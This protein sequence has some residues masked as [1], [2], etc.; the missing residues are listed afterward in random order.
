MSQLLI[1]SDLAVGHM[2]TLGI[3]R[4]IAGQQVSH[5]ADDTIGT[6]GLT[7]WLKGNVVQLLI[8]LIGAGC[9]LAA[10]KVQMAK[11]M[12]MVGGTLVAL[13]V[14]GL[15]NPGMSDKVG[16]FLFGLFVH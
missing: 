14:L 16:N 10:L 15:S 4:T 7:T 1:V 9:L 6:G 11:I 13:S 3:V 12:L 2:N 5:L 8:L